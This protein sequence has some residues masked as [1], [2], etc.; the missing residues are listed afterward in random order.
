MK[1]STDCVGWDSDFWGKSARALC[2]ALESNLVDFNETNPHSWPPVLVDTMAQKLRK[3]WAFS[4]WRRRAFAENYAALSTLL[5][6]LRAQ[7]LS[8]FYGRRHCQEI[9]RV[10]HER[11]RNRS[12]QVRLSSGL[13]GKRIEYRERGRSQTQREPQQSRWFLIRHLQTLL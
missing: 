1:A 6:K 13:I 9:R 11:F 12:I 4:S 3:P 2:V 7:N 5:Q 8:W 10:S